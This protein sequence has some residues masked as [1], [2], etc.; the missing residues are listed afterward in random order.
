[1]PRQRAEV[2]AGLSGRRAAALCC[3]QEHIREGEREVED[4]VDGVY[5]GLPG[6]VGAVAWTGYM[7]GCQ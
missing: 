6:D 2:D 7:C 4:V 5:E 1:V 3:V